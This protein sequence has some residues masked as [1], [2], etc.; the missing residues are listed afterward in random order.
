[1]ATKIVA[2]SAAA[3]ESGG[4]SGRA[5]YKPNFRNDLFIDP[6]ATSVMFVACALAQHFS[7]STPSVDAMCERFGMSRATAYRWKRAWIDA[8]GAGQ[9]IASKGV[10]S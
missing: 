9:K 8:T 3:T 2:T 4:K 1:M 10:A 6:A 5:H 7:R